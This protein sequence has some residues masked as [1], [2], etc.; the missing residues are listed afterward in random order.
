MV[1]KFINYIVH[2]GKNEISGRSLSTHPKYNINLAIFK[3]LRMQLIF[4]TSLINFMLHQLE[5]WMGFG[6]QAP[7]K[8]QEQ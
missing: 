7:S 3:T 2:S 5:F 6:K 4:L 1:P 8:C